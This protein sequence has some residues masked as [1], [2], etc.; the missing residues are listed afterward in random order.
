VR[1]SN[2]GDVP[3]VLASRIMDLWGIVFAS[4]ETLSDEPLIMNVS[5]CSF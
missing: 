5:R 1:L 2:P 3:E 4:A